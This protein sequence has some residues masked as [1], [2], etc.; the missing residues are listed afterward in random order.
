MKFVVYSLKS[1]RF[2]K[3]YIEFTSNL[4]QRFYANNYRSNKGYS[5]KSTL[6]RKLILLIYDFFKLLIMQF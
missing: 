4:I 3:I 5:K 6:N 2:N 1:S